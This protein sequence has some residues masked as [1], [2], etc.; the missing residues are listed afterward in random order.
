[1]LPRRGPG[2]AAKSIREVVFG[3]EDG[4][5]QNLTLIAGMVGEGCR[6]Q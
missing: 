5:V 2:I 6:A 1:M 3:I 4:V